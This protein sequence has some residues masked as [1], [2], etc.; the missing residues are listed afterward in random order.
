[1]PETTALGAAIAAGLAEGI[2]VWKLDTTLNS[3]DKTADVFTPSISEASK[4]LLLRYCI[5]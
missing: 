5:Q 4:L 2:D 1:M 3:V